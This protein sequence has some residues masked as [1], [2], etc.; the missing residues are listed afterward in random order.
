MRLVDKGMFQSWFAR[1][2]VHQRRRDPKARTVQTGTRTTSPGRLLLPLPSPLLCSELLLAGPLLPLNSF[3]RQQTL[4]LVSLWCP[5]GVCP[6]GD[7]PE[8]A[9]SQGDSGQRGEPC[10]LRFLA[11]EQSRRPLP[12]VGGPEQLPENGRWGLIWALRG[13][14]VGLA[15][16]GTCREWGGVTVRSCATEPGYGDGNSAETFLHCGC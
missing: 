4:S 13:G 6:S 10:A 3:L 2:S 5:F 9:A 1:L 11:P 15:Q 12:A 14:E 16:T 7:F 8:A